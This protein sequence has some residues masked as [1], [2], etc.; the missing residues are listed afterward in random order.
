MMK[1]VSETSA[2]QEAVNRNT[3]QIFLEQNDDA[4]AQSTKIEAFKSLNQWK[5]YRKLI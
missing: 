1:D 5:K 3:A 2:S 4:S